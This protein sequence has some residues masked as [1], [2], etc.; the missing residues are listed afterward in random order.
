M[1]G[2]DEV[3]TQNEHNCPS[4]QRG[5]PIT[6]QAQAIGIA[7]MHGVV[8]PVIDHE[9]AEHC[10]HR[11]RQ[12]VGLWVPTATQPDERQRRQPDRPERR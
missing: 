7:R 8:I 6:E 10:H 11:Q 5:E 4:R 3:G 9:E 2:Q 12:Q 1:E